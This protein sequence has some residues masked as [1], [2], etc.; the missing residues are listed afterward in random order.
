MVEIWLIAQ[1]YAAK[2]PCFLAKCLKRGGV[3]MTADI[4]RIVELAKEQGVSHAH[5]A[6]KIGKYRTVISEWRN[7]KATPTEND[8]RIIA[9]ELGTTP[10]YLMGKVD[11]AMLSW[12]AAFRCN[13]AEHLETVNEADMEAAG[14]SVN[15]ITSV[16]KSTKAIQL[17][18]ASDIADQL[19]VDLNVLIG[20]EPPTPVP[21]AWDGVAPEVA[22]LLK[23]L[24][25]ERIPE[26]L[27]Y[28]EFQ[29]GCA[30]K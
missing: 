13:L 30:D 2:A 7:K 5:L 27:R 25:P 26:V 12:E 6:R 19:G 16:L 23:R 17:E 22:T 3:L 24:P 8:I 9:I 21:D 28:L 15:E 10:D 18:W 1:H 11:S 4:G 29:V 20:N 14:I